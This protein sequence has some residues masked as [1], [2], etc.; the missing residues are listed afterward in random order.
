MKFS[1]CQK[2]EN[3]LI[4]DNY[5]DDNKNKIKEKNYEKDFSVSENNNHLNISNAKDKKTLLW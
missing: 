4:K 5:E 3:C 1:N 2:K